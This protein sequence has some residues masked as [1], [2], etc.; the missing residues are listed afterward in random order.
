MAPSCVTLYLVVNKTVPKN[1]R[2][3][4][5]LFQY[6]FIT[7]NCRRTIFLKDIDVLITIGNLS[8]NINKAAVDNGYT[9]LTY[10]YDTV[11]DFLNDYKNVVKDNDI[12]LLKASHSMNFRKILDTLNK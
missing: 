3:Q 7:F 10:V 4:V 12:I 8:K 1:V 9:G 6:H 11:D 2:P 5:V